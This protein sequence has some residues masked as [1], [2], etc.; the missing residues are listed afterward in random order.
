MAAPQ[1]DSFPFNQ[2]VA[3]TPDPESIQ[4]S[5]LAAFM[6]RQIYEIENHDENSLESILRRSV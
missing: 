5:N 6:D 4:A 1:P 3:W 2:D